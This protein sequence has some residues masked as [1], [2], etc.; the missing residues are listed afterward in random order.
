V[1]KRCVVHKARHKKRQITKRGRNDNRNKRRKV[2]ELGV[3]SDEDPSLEPSWSGDVT[4]EAV[5]WSNMSG[6]SSSSSPR[7][8]EVSSSW[9]S[10][11]TRRDKTIGSSSRQVAHPAQE[12]QRM[13]C[14]R[15]VPSGTG[16]ST[17][18]RSAPRQVKPLK[19]SEERPTSARQPYD[20]SDHLDSDSLQWRQSQGRSSDSAS[21]LSAPPVAEP[22]AT[23]W[24]LQS[25]LIRGGGAPDVHVS[26]VTGGGHSPTPAVAEAGGLAPERLG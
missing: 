20:G 21:T 6:S 19:R 25:L 12:D 16:A 14:T 2:G 5:D 4:S 8:T 18:Q 23:P 3:S 24:R 17:P 13:V 11:A 10:Q 7:G 15:A 22:S 26:L 9:R 1:E